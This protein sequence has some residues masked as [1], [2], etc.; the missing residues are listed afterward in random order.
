[1]N[2]AMLSI[3][4]GNDESAHIQAH[5]YACAQLTNTNML[6]DLIQERSYGHEDGYDDWSLMHLNSLNLNFS[7]WYRP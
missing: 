5:E 6:T 2:R 4:D 3:V 1:M 7:W